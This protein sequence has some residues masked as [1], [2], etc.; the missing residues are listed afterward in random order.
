MTT[1][2]PSN[3]DLEVIELAPSR[4]RSSV[5]VRDRRAHRRALKDEPAKKRGVKSKFVGERHEFIQANMEALRVARQARKRPLQDAFWERFFADY[6]AKFNWQ[7]PLDKDP[8]PDD[9]WKSDS[10]LSEEELALKSQ[11][12]AKTVQVCSVVLMVLASP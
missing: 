7:L 11:V 1:P 2:T 12:V 5:A 3:V 6:W 4:Y 9:V 10:E 8:Q